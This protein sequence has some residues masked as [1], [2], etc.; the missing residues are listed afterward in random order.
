M[1]VTQG[2]E[3]KPVMTDNF[4]LVPPPAE[5]GKA[6]RVVSKAEAAK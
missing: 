4:V 1:T 2:A 3:L 6:I 5:E